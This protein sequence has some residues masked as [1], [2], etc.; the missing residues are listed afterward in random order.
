[1]IKTNRFHCS[2]CDTIFQIEELNDQDPQVEICRRCCAVIDAGNAKYDQDY[3]AMYAYQ[4]CIDYIDK[5]RAKRKI[6]DAKLKEIIN[7]L[8]L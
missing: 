5:D 6:D 8:Y 4:D 2:E 7:E 3:K 1:M